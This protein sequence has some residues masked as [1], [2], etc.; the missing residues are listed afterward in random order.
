MIFVRC[1]AQPYTGR[2]LSS[3]PPNGL[4]V[5]VIAKNVQLPVYHITFWP[6]VNGL[7]QKYIILSRKEAEGIGG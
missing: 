4:L 2:L 1:A 6:F 5:L 3:P 7:R